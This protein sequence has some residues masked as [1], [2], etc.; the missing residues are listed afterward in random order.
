M[1]YSSLTTLT[2][3]ILKRFK[4]FFL[5]T[6]LRKILR[7]RTCVQKFRGNRSKRFGH[8]RGHKLT[9]NQTFVSLTLSK[10]ISLDSLVHPIGSL[11][12]HLIATK[13]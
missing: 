7:L 6:N 1:S 10:S 12:I 13:L 4:L 9:L 11:V 2:A 8:Y 3:T 5:L